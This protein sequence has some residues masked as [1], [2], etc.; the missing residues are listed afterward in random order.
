MAYRLLKT[1]QK[2]E[3]QILSNTKN[4]TILRNYNV[5]A[6]QGRHTNGRRARIPFIHF[7]RVLQLIHDAA[8]TRS[9]RLDVPNASLHSLLAKYLDW[10][11]SKPKGF[12]KFFGD[13]PPKSGS[14]KPDEPTRKLPEDAS[15]SKD[16]KEFEKKIENLFFKEKAKSTNGGGK[17]RPID[18][19]DDKGTYYKAGFI[20]ATAIALG[21]M[22]YTYY[23]QTE[24]SWKEFIGWVRLN[25]SHFG[26][27]I[28]SNHSFR[29][30]CDQR[31][32]H[33]TRCGQQKMGSCVSGSRIIGWIRKY[34]LYPPVRS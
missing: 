25:R 23:A 10:F 21:I 5:S 30:I 24:I 7:I 29:Q 1:V 33:F 11:S 14:K 22:Y 32:S 28:I 27:W 31:W 16:F 4:A 18:G 26:L 17:G 13:E 6:T 9:V 34:P 2:L 19:G 20:A 15:N 12:G 8:I 3:N